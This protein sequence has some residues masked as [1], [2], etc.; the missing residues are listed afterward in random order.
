MHLDAA[1][2]NFQLN[3]HL[4][5]P[6]NIH[7]LYHTLNR[8]NLTEPISQGNQQTETLRSW[9]SSDSFSKIFKKKCFLKIPHVIKLRKII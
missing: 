4:C 5:A 8:P 6:A 9:S 7:K 2:G 1:T 3:S